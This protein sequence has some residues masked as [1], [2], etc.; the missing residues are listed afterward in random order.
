MVKKFY[1]IRKKPNEH[2]DGLK[3]TIKE[4][5]HA[6]NPETFHKDMEIYGR[7]AQ[8]MDSFASGVEVYIEFLLK[9]DLDFSI[10][11]IEEVFTQGNQGEGEGADEDE[12]PPVEEPPVSDEDTPVIID[13]LIDDEEPEEDPELS[14]EEIVKE[15]QAEEFKDFM[16][17]LNE[18]AT[19]D[20]ELE[21]DYQKFIETLEGM[22]PEERERFLEYLKGMLDPNADE[23]E[24]EGKS[25]NVYKALEDYSKLTELDKK[26][27]GHQPKA[28]T[29]QHQPQRGKHHH[30]F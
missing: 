6:Y 10:S 14:D 26:S 20:E 4:Y 11:L 1:S 28:T 8:A 5:P 22:S 30:R 17:L 12:E 25:L 18:I 19:P 23:A 3:E 16:S 24:G 21:G 15:E 2:I 27:A 13:D 29:R 9:G 7:S